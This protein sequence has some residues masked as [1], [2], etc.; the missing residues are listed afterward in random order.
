MTQTLQFQHSVEGFVND[1]NWIPISATTIL[2]AIGFV[3]LLNLLLSF[4]EIFGF[5][6]GAYYDDDADK[7]NHFNYDAIG[8][9]L[10]YRDE[11]L[12]AK[13]T[14]GKIEEL[15]KTGFITKERLSEL[16]SSSEVNKA[17]SLLNSQM[18]AM[19]SPD[20]LKTLEKMFGG[21]K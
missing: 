17:L 16:G 13:H 10:N 20:K 18:G 7:N 11:L 15:K 19:H 12:K 9:G 6:T 21:A 8:D 2:G 5:S 14:P 3:M 1:N 4:T